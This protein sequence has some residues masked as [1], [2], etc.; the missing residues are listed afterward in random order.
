MSEMLTAKQAERLK[1]ALGEY[2][3]IERSNEM[4]EEELE[5]AELLSEQ[6]RDEL[7]RPTIGCYNEAANGGRWWE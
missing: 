3:R 7:E 2:E 1:T 5:R 6:S 4:N